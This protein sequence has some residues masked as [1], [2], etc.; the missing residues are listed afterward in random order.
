MNDT[1]FP[2][3][4]EDVVATLTDIY[5]HQ[6]QPDIV[7]LLES[8]NAR[9]EETNYDNLNGGTSFYTLM[10]DVPVAVFATVEPKLSEVEKSISSKLGIICR[11]LI[12]DHL[13]SVTI[14]PL[15]S[16]S[17][18]VGPK[19][20]PADIEVKHL[21]TEG[22]FRL[23]LSHVSLHKVD[24]AKIKTE[25][26]L[27]GISAF[28]AHEDIKPS[29][30]WQNEI[31]LALRS[32]HALAALLTPEFHTSEWTDQEVGFALGRGVL[33]VPIG[34]GLIPYGFIGKVQGMRS[35][36][37]Q[38][39]RLANQLFSTLLEHP[40]THRH[41]RKGLA[42]AFAAAGSFSSAISLSKVILTVKGFAA[43]EK[44]VIE[45]AC[46]ENDQ[47]INATGVVSRVCAAIGIR[48]PNKAADADDIPF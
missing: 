33:V 17:A 40:S 15:T 48:N 45:R 21:W 32:M 11:N 8:S 35:S 4:V 12:N 47:V 42:Y 43:D 14:T 18:S 26:R 46:E 13:D 34:L 25:L 24:L 39:S 6:G 38:P 7:E 37:E 22:F 30:E 29:L 36:L 44:T 23:F 41:M 31:E 5:R 28:I 19:A 10:L 9:I 3:A 2:K 1:G 20:K 16:K 27:H